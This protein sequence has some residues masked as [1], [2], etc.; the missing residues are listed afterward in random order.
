V[1]NPR[2]KYLGEGVTTMPSGSDWLVSQYVYLLID[3]DGVTYEK[4]IE[5]SDKELVA[6][7]LGF[8]PQPGEKTT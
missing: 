1:I 7:H 4:K 8:V 3:I 5:V 6:R 2:L